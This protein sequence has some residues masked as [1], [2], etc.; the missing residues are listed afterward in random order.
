MLWRSIITISKSNGR[1]YVK[2][3]VV[4]IPAVDLSKRLISSIDAVTVEST[5]TTVQIIAAESTR[6]NDVLVTIN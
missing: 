1:A 5:K 3:A 4:D 6:L 2:F